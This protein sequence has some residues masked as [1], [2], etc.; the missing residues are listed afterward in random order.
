M[1][2]L[3][4]LSQTSSPGLVKLQQKKLLLLRKKKSYQQVLFCIK[5]SMI[6]IQ[7][8]TTEDAPVDDLEGSDYQNNLL[9]FREEEHLE[10]FYLA[11][12]LFLS[13]LLYHIMKKTVE[14]SRKRARLLQELQKRRVETG[15][16]GKSQPTLG[17]L[18]QISFH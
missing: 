1:R 15:E 9:F 7:S 4:S 8:G 16:Q 3:R 5:F 13:F 11:S 12:F 17:V 14:N 2:S 10:L 6:N 18:R